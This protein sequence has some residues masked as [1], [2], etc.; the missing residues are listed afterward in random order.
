MKRRQQSFNITQE[1]IEIFEKA[2]H[3]KVHCHAQPE[4]GQSTAGIRLMKNQ[5]RRCIIE[6]GRDAK[7]NQKPPIPPAIK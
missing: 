3:C 2:K 4:Q 1:E 5:E 6:A 7:K